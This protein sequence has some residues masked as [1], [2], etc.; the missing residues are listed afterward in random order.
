MDSDQLDKTTSRAE[1]GMRV[2][3][4]FPNFY[5]GGEDRGLGHFI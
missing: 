2:G 4:F 3:M 5:G 1:C